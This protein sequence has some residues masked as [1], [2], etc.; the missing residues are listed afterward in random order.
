MVNI[1]VREL[2]GTDAGLLEQFTFLALWPPQIV[3]LP[4]AQL[5]AD[6]RLQQYW[7]GFGRPGD[8]GF[9]A[10]IG[11]QTVGA[12][13]A[14]IIPAGY[15]HVDALTPELSIAVV[16]EWRGKG[17][18]TQLMDVL[19][20]SLADAGYQSVSLSVQQTNPAVRLYKR[21]GF[22]VVRVHDSE[23][24]MVRG[25]RPIDDTVA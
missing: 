13:W 14:R 5:R 2:T 11:S 4:S 24:I 3:A 25:L 23:F 17:V 21:F 8:I 22:T 19:L 12:S 9:A 18:G 16:P 20:D 7:Q 15:G 6:P 1:Q 10:L